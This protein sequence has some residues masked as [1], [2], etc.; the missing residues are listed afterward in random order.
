[1]SSESQSATF[2]RKKYF[3]L[4]IPVIALFALALLMR[5]S[6]GGQ[7]APTSEQAKK[8]L[9]NVISIQLRDNYIQQRLS[10]GRVEANQT[11]AIGFDLAGSVIELL[12]D[13]GD[14]VSQGQI[15]ARL[16][17]QRL[18]AQ[19]SE[20]NAVLRRAKSEAKL[21]EI[22]FNRVT[23]LVAKKLESAQILDETREGLTAASAF[24]DEVIARQQRLQVE[25]LKTQL[26]APFTGT[27]VS[28]LVDKGAVVNAGQTLFSLQQNS[29]LEV[30]FATPAN[31]TE[32]LQVGQ[33]INLQ[34]DDSQFPGEIKS[35]SHLRRLDTRTV[36]LIVS[37]VEKDSAFLPGDILYLSMDSNIET[38]GF[39]VPRQALVSGVRGLWSLFVVEQVAGEYELVAK[40]VEMIHAND[41][42]VFIRGELKHGQK[43][44]V[45]GVQRL[46]PG[47]KV[48]LT[49]NQYR[50]QSS[51]KGLL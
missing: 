40:L 10:I 4:V 17:Q 19:M 44:V 9:V 2:K 30:R 36:D 13:E 50:A 41:K 15:L 37:L 25:L 27:V 7:T 51:A 29:S 28:R 26:F 21:T 18:N 14:V 5:A 43:V 35:I 42:D 11:T 8:H 31:Y 6:G 49:G 23:E 1:M 33:S 39:W 38:I 22:S 46:V 32:N 3:V 34:L 12:V 48:V 20:L 47:Q 45:D 24:V 16:D